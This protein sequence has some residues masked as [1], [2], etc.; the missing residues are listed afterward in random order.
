MEAS[1]LVFR[2]ENLLKSAQN[3]MHLE[4]KRVLNLIENNIIK[5]DLV[6]RKIRWRLTAE[7][8]SIFDIL[9]PSSR[10]E[11]C[12]SLFL[13]HLLDPKE[14]H[15]Q[16]SVFLDGFVSLLTQLAVEQKIS[17]GDA[18]PDDWRN[19]R[20]VT[21]LAHDDGR[22][23]IVIELAGRA[24]IVIENKVR[25]PE[26][27]RQMARYGKWLDNIKLSSRALV[28]L[29]P[30]GRSSETSED[31]EVINMS[32][33]QLA[34]CLTNALDRVKT[35]AVPVISVVRQY[36][37][38][39]NYIFTGEQ[40]MAHVNKEVFELLNTPSH[41]EVALEI[42]AYVEEIKPRIQNKFI[43]NVIDLLNRKIQSED[44]SCKWLAS[45]LTPWG[46]GS[47]SISTGLSNFMVLYGNIFHPTDPWE[48][49]SGWHHSGNAIDHNHPDIINLVNKM[50]DTCPR[51]TENCW[52]CCAVGKNTDIQTLNMSWNDA[53][54]KVALLKDN[55][56][57]HLNDNTTLANNLADAMWELFSRFRADVEN[58]PM[59][60]S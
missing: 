59:F 6:E 50:A 17:F 48:H 35:T 39:C 26:Q 10:E 1:N 45:N 40:T 54:T 8:Y 3:F 60:K 33:Q 46:D 57:D 23:D 4:A 53:E 7:R 2:V 11:T 47:I 55:Q 42:S 34:T 9:I 52:L 51:S 44:N 43:A 19:A 32:Y 41:F 18:W 14:N 37:D 28:F 38:L 13:R 21:E 36:T 30:S 27:D 15:D 56:K 31:Y 25:A 49:Q 20:V 58:L 24:C 29:T 12:H 5:S 22:I 16:G